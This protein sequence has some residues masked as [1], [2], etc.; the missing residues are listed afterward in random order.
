MK[1]F[2]PFFASAA[3][4]LP[5][6]HSPHV[7]AEDAL[8]K[9]LLTTRGKLLVS[10]NFAGPLAPL[11]G[12]PVGFASGFTGWRFAAPEAAGRS[13]S[14]EVKE[15]VFQGVEKPGANHPATAS[16]GIRY[17]NAV[18]Q[19]EV[20]MENAPEEGRKYRSFFVKATDASGYV[21]ALFGSPGGVNALAYDAEKID[22]ANKQRAKQPQVSAPVKV[23][24]DEWHTVVL[25]ILGT[26]LVAT[27][28][29][30]SVT[31]SS[32]LVGAEK[33]SVMFG[34]GTQA[35]FR[36]FRMWEAQPNPE[37]PKN[38]EGLPARVN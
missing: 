33:H 15:G 23:A 3:F 31:L 35:S 17:Q 30:K 26:E 4:L 9:T 7:R 2:R 36:N 12:K 11:I 34:V 16:F 5:M 6:F 20:R 21:C 38:K 14:W 37:W 24:L 19:C 25:E 18:I 28:D 22:P 29:G 32:P 10:E 8:P 1:N 27:L 13:G